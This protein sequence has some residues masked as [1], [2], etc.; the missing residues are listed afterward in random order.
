MVE[1]VAEGFEGIVDLQL[2]IKINHEDTKDT[3]DSGLWCYL[4]SLVP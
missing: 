1:A 2:A 4:V 3:K